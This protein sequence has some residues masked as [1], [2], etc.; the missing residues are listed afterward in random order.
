MASDEVAPT[1][2]A[3]TATIPAG[4]RPV[5]ARAA[6][7]AGYAAQGFGYATVVT[8]LPALKGRQGIDD[9]MVSVTVLVVCLAAAGGSM[10]ADRVAARQGSRT[11][12]VS[13]LAIQALALPV[14]AVHLPLGAFVLAFA[15]Y[16]TG[17]GMVDASTGM[18]A[19]QVQRR[20]GT[21]I[22]SGFF[23]C[24]TGAA[25]AG[26]LLMSAVASSASALGVTLLA[27]TGVLAGTAVVGRRELLP[28]GREHLD[29]P[30]MALE[31]A[32]G[33]AGLEGAHL[34]PALAA[35]QGRRGAGPLPMTGIWVFGSV[36]L[37]AFVAD[38]AVSTWSSVYLSDVLLTS[39]AVAP[40]GYAAY[41]GTIL[42]SRAL[43]DV[44]VR[45]VGRVAVAVAS[46]LI[47]A[48]GLALVVVVHS[49][50]AAIVGFAATGVGVGTLVPLAFSAAGDIDPGRSD[51]VVARVNLFNYAGAVLGAVA[52]GLLSAG[53]G[54]AV[55]FLVPLLLLGP[56]ALIAR[57]FAP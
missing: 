42:A 30:A 21:S 20:Y 53:P 31:A 33:H 48:A 44:L 1:S 13:G 15:V 28:P 50:G 57:R 19:V 22:M 25:I 39:A 55:G 47:S 23:A 32:A 51:E 18:Q 5:R 11:A 12:L 10:L 8:A 38:S 27:A 49:P 56:V 45:R 36:V 40:L 29:D 35:G 3:A 43:G 41:Q 17:L 4:P 54:L 2:P 24:Y 52:V 37:A 7:S 16:G 34:D 46:P 14:I 26:A 9:A 6:T